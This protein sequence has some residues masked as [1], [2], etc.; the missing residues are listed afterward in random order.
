MNNKKYRPDATPV[1]I[2]KELVKAF[3]IETLKRNT[4]MRDVLE[5]YIKIWMKKGETK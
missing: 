2:E 3:R 1:Q 4:S 5:N